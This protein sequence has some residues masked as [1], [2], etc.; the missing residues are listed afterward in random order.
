[1]ATL[2]RQQRSE[3]SLVQRAASWL[4]TTAAL[5]AGLLLAV[6]VAHTILEMGL[7]YF[8][9]TSTFVL[10]EFVGYQVAAVTMLG[11]GHALNR[12]GLIRVSLVTRLL[13]QRAQRALELIAVVLVVL[14]SA[15]IAHYYVLA[16]WTAFSRGTRSNTFAETPLWV[17][18]SVFLAGLIVFTIQLLAYALRLVGGGSLITD[19]TEGT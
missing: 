13:P 16:I 4:A 7:R 8:L 15:F 9:G 14:L 1:M 5:L 3:A 18:M 2:G 6:M 12:G 11:L 10:D 19:R 17:P